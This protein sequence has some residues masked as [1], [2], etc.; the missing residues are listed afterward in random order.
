MSDPHPPDTERRTKRPCN[1]GHHSVW[2]EKY[3][4]ICRFPGGC[5]RFC[6]RFAERK[7]AHRGR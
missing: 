1:C 2:H 4:G 3:R 6:T 7:E 5:R